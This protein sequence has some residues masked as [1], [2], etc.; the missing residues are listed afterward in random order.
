MLAERK[1]H[2]T[3]VLKLLAKEYP[4]AH[5]ALVH[6]NPFELLV[7]T[8]LSAQCTDK[9]VNTVTPGLFSLY[10]TAATLATAPQADVEQAIRKIGLFRNKAKNIIACA[11][12]LVEKHQGEVPQTLEELVAL[13]GVGR[14]TANVVLGDAFGVPGVVVDTHVHRL[15]RRLGLTEKD[16]PIHIEAD[17]MT[18]I[19]KES[20]TIL[21]HRLI[22]HG[23]AV[24]DAK[25]PKC[26]SCS[27]SKICPRNEVDPKKMV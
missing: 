5:C 19:P 26:S 24:C 7:A 8:I 2:A 11:Q 3:K 10:P 6:K 9:L 17:L 21:G 12:G 13:P 1:K 22:Y 23:R 15:S 14:K 18:I 27:L 4:T 16:T 20:W 25:K